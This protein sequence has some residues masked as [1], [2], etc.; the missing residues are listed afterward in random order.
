MEQDNRP[1]QMPLKEPEGSSGQLGLLSVLWLVAVVGLLVMF[2][3]GT[4]TNREDHAPGGATAMAPQA[5]PPVTKTELPATRVPAFDTANAEHILLAWAEQGMYMTTDADSVF[6]LLPAGGSLRAQLIRRGPQPGPVTENVSITW[7]VEAAHADAARPESQ[8]GA[9]TLQEGTAVFNANA[10][11]LLPYRNDGTFGPYPLLTIEARDAASGALLATTNAVLPVST[12]LGCRSCHGGEWAKGVAGISTATATSILETHDRINGTNLQQQAAAGTPVQCRSCH[13]GNP[14]DAQAPTSGKGLS[15]S[16]AMHGWHASYLSG[17]GA[18]ACASCHP[19]DK[20]GATGF[21]RGL[22]ANKGLDCTRCHGTME[23]HALSLLKGEMAQGRKPVERLAAPLKPRAVASVDAI[24]ARTPWSMMPDCA[25]CHDFTAKPKSATASAFN[26]WTPNGDE[27]Y[28]ARTEMM[29]TLRC[30]A[31]HG[32][33]HA[34]YPA[35]NPQSRDRDNV[36]PLQYQK[37]AKVMGGANNCITCHREALPMEASAHHPV[38]VREAK[39]ITLPAGTTLTKPVVQFPHGAHQRVD[40][41]TCHH[42]DYQENASQ[43]CTNKGCHDMQRPGDVA[44]LGD[45]KYFRNAFHGRERG[46]MTCHS[47]LLR[48]GKAA[49][50][51]ECKDCHTP[52]ANP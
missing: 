32:S 43:S 21:M 10:I 22:H 29:G 40:C 39:P 28:V 37:H 25:G 1:L 12:E 33:P 48:A 20:R 44:Q 51:T 30:P 6:T 5:A 9:F 47:A 23:D 34:E 3:A 36:Q 38:V 52:Q 35:R 46:C 49:G 2:I 4:A 42:K 31:C 27:R 15:I 7:Q 18:E 17:R 41:R 24:N 16:A 26:Q 14:P 8:Q 11:P 45:P 19:S 13:A 50:P